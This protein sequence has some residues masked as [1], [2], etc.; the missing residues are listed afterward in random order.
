V[1]ARPLPH[2][3][4]ARNNKIDSL[5]ISNSLFFLVFAAEMHFPSEKETKNQHERTPAAT[6]V[7]GR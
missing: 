2:S 4:S 5:F 3:P 7:P 6:H 1:F